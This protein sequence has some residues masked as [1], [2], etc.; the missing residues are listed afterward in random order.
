MRSLTGTSAMYSETIRV[1]SLIDDEVAQLESA[2]DEF[3]RVVDRAA[4]TGAW[5]RHGVEFH[6]SAIAFGSDSHL[7]I[8][9]PGRPGVIRPRF[10]R[11][12]ARDSEGSPVMATQTKPATHSP[13]PWKFERFNETSSGYRGMCVVNADGANIANIVGQLDDTEL[14]NAKLIA[15]APRLLGLCETTLALL[16]GRSPRPTPAML[17]ELES[18]LKK[19]LAAAKGSAKRKAGVK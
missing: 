8:R 6:I 3:R 19:E 4:D 7:T 13:G 17:A 15:A 14:A 12:G 18:L 1:Q 9:V 5:D 11:D 10:D 2:R 16:D